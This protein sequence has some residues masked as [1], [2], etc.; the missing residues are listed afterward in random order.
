LGNGDLNVKITD[1]LISWYVSNVIVPK[2]EEL[3]HPGFII[4]KL[5]SN[6][7]EIKLREIAFPERLF[8]ELG[9]EIVR[10][11]GEAGEQA[12]YSAGKKFGYGYAS[13]ACLEDLK[14]TSSEKEFLNSTSYLVMYVASLFAKE[15]KHSINLGEKRFDADM[16]DYIIC[17]KNGKGFILS[18]GGITGIWAYLMGDK[19]IE[20]VQ[21]K[22]EGRGDD[23]CHVV[24][25]P[26]TW[27]KQAGHRYYVEDDLSNL[28]I[29]D[30]YEEMNAVRTAQYA[31]NSLESL[32]ETG[33]FEY[34]E[35]KLSFRGERYFICEAHLMYYLEK[36]LKKLPGAERVLFDIAYK[37]GND[38]AG[39]I[40]DDRCEAFIMD[41]LPAL[42]FGDIFIKSDDGKYKISSSYFPWTEYLTDLNFTLFR[43]LCSGII[44]KFTTNKVIFEHVETSEAEGYLDLIIS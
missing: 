30:S 6:T 34:K 39:N 25:A 12:L 41:Y 10:E 44:S 5:S 31:K 36:E 16:W 1:N 37:F 17:R 32:L 42:G 14:S 38:V 3:D 2:T 22:C 11:F 26:P 7:N 28:K 9:K 8:V 23:R 20:G 33:F 4:S 18:S 35:G 43:G 24:C 21:T 19:T 13:L 29:S 40:T 15:I 27:L